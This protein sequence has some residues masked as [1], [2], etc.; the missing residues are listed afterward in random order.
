MS[1]LH[2]NT[3]L[4]LC[5]MRLRKEIDV[6][7]FLKELHTRGI[8]MTAAQLAAIEEGYLLPSDPQIQGNLPSPSLKQYLRSR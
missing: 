3:G 5:S 2:Y 7:T 8:E 6:P 1:Q 4:I